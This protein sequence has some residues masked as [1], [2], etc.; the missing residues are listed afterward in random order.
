MLI[1]YLSYAGKSLDEVRSFSIDGQIDLMISADGDL[2]SE[3]VSSPD[4]LSEFVRFVEHPG[5]A[6]LANHCTATSCSVS[7]VCVLPGANTLLQPGDMIE[8]GL[9][10]L[11]VDT[12]PA[13]T[14][15]F[16]EP[17][18]SSDLAAQPDAFDDL[19]A[20]AGP[21]AAY[22]SAS[23]PAVTGYPDR[24]A[25]EIPPA[26]AQTRLTG[27]DED[28]LTG[29][30]VEYQ[31]ALRHYERDTQD[32]ARADVQQRNPCL[33]E[34]P[35][36]SKAMQ[37]PGTLLDDLLQDKKNIDVVIAGLDQFGHAT[38]FADEP[39]TEILGLL[40][41]EGMVLPPQTSTAR[42]TQREH[43]IV[44]MDS[45][46]DLPGADNETRMSKP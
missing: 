31:R 38:L 27:I 22:E 10:R 43:H 39:F 4:P 19:I 30:S 7:G 3:V 37:R 16:N 45:H 42:L 13:A 21:V 15:S 9:S 23:T 1:R 24:F 18:P 25:C 12:D 46:F 6:E 14:R 40:A 20:L 28:P 8:V 17:S 35:L 26:V 33:F 11:R 34:D 5:G 44:S 32:H 2:V 36:D 29:L 41:P